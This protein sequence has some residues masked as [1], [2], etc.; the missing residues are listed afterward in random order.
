MTAQRAADCSGIDEW[1]QAIGELQQGLDA[2]AN[3]PTVSYGTL[4]SEPYHQAAQEM[5]RIEAP[6]VVAEAHEAIRLGYSTLADEIDA[7]IAVSQGMS[8]GQM[9]AYDVQSNIVV[10]LSEARR[11]L[12]GGFLAWTVAGVTC[13]ITTA[14]FTPAEING[15]D[16]VADYLNTAAATIGGFWNFWSDTANQNQTDTSALPLGT[17]EILS[18]AAFEDAFKLARTPAPEAAMDIQLATV[19]YLGSLAD[20]YLLNLLGAM[21]VYYGLDQA[22]VNQIVDQHQQQLELTQKQAEDIEADW[23]TLRRSCRVDTRFPQAGATDLP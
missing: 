2:A 13:G 19:T 12:L 10:Q 22:S 8:A 11:Q 4:N 21:G 1:Y 15:C 18:G 9:P 23:N 17:G 3:D 14:Q 5:Q 20:L 16:G 6:E 7:S